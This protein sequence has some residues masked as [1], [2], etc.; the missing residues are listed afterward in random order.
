MYQL[1]HRKTNKTH[2]CEKTY[3]DG[4]LFYVNKEL[5]IIACKEPNMGHPCV[6]DEVAVK[7]DQFCFWQSHQTKTLYYE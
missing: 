4:V 5:K 1:I 6:I 2:L 7:A 3:I